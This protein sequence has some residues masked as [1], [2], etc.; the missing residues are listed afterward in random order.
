MMCNGGDVAKPSA[1]VWKRVVEGMC[2]FL[3]LYTLLFLCYRIPHKSSWNIFTLTNSY[4]FYFQS[5]FENIYRDHIFENKES[6]AKLS[7][8]LKFRA[9][10]CYN[11]PCRID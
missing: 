10:I 8:F 2:K 6:F 4:H 5:N 3:S 11:N 7:S 1:S 9:F